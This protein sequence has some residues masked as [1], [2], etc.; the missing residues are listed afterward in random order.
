MAGTGTKAVLA[1]RPRKP[2]RAAKTS[3]ARNGACAC[4]CARVGCVPTAFAHPNSRPGPY[5]FIHPCPYGSPMPSAHVALAFI[6]AF[7]SAFVFAF[8]FAF[9]PAFISAFVSY[10]IRLR[11]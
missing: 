10:R 1:W 7:V 2:S 5:V 8:V 3:P 11:F 6:S 4:A 9:I